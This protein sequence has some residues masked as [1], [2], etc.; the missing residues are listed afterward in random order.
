VP[1]L[2]LQPLRKILYI[3]GSSVGQH[4]LQQTPDALIAIEFGAVGRKVFQV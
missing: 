1:E 3:V 2:L 4:A